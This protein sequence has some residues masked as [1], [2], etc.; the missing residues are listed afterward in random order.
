MCL[1][2]GDL[3]APSMGQLR[4]P[5]SRV[6]TGRGS[7][8]K[9]QSGCWQGSCGAVEAPVAPGTPRNETAGRGAVYLAEGRMSKNPEASL[10]LGGENQA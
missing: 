1:S 6:S 2:S 5:L 7:G 3:L 4:W 10:L 8:D 9:Q